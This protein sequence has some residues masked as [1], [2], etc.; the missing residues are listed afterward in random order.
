MRS[1]L[2]KGRDPFVVI[3]EEEFSN[4]IP[5]FI[6]QSCSAFL[7]SYVYPKTVHFQTILYFFVL[8][9]RRHTSIH[10]LTGIMTAARIWPSQDFTLYLLEYAS[11]EPNQRTE[12]RRFS[13]RQ[14]CTNGG[15]E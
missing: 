9:C 12:T 5:S 11:F 8:A 10:L 3:A 2:D 1:T 7:L 6:L 14:D 13:C 15:H 4:N